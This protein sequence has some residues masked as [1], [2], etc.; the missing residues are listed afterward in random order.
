MGPRD[1]FK[2][3]FIGEG[4]I[5]LEPRGSIAEARNLGAR[6]T[7]GDPLLFLDSDMNL[8]GVDLSRISLRG[9]DFA[10][11]WY[12]ARKTADWPWCWYQN[13]TAVSN[14]PEAFY[15]GFVLV[16]RRAFEALR[17]F[18]NTPREDVEFAWRAFWKG[19]KLGA[20]PMK[21]V[22]MKP[23]NHRTAAQMLPIGWGV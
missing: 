7:K 18:K 8:G 9:L 11:A 1:E 6:K 13:L 12:D 22:H 2:K 10:T 16:R 14:S 4:E 19:F 5:I 21:V 23:F 3:T 17:G 20:I 15:G